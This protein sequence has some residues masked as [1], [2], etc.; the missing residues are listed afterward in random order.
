M[1]SSIRHRDVEL[2]NLQEIPATTNI[3]NNLLY[4]PQ[5]EENQ[6][7]AE[8]SQIS[9]IRREQ[10]SLT[11]FLGCGA[12]GEVYEGQ[13]KNLLYVNIETKVAVKVSIDFT[14]D[15]VLMNHG[16]CWS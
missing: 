7:A 12:F 6:I 10:I 1:T 4:I 2:V 8:F 13:V 3:K 9:R 5:I 16:I 14:V 15:F 11:K